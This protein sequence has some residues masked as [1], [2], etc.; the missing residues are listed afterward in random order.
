VISKA[1]QE[2]GGKT[3]YTITAEGCTEL[4]IWLTTVEASISAMSCLSS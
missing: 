1:S 4:V 2:G 3:F